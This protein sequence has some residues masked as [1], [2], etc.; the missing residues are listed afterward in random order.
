MRSYV[1][2]DRQAWERYLATLLPKQK[3]DCGS[4][5]KG[6]CYGRCYGDLAKGGAPHPS[7]KGG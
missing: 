7:R 5:M 2:D 6:Q 3:C 4:E 1:K